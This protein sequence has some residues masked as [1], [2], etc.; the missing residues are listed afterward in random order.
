ML[1][2]L[3]RDQLDKVLARRRAWGADKLDNVFQHKQSI[4]RS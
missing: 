1:V 4:T 2:L 3:E